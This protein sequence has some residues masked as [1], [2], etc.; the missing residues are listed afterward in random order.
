M[1]ILSFEERIVKSD[2]TGNNMTLAVTKI[3]GK[4]IFEIFEPYEREA[5]EN[6][7]SKYAGWGYEYQFADRLFEQLIT[8]SSA[9]SENEAALMICNG[10]YEEGCWPLLVTIDESDTEITWR[11]F[12]NHHRSIPAQDGTFWDYSAFPSFHFSK[13]AYEASLI[14]LLKIAGGTYR[15]STHHRKQLENDKICG[16]FSCI[17]LFPPS[18][19]IEWCYEE[20]DGEGVTAICPYCGIDAIIGESTGLPMTQDF[21]QLLNRYS[22]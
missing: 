18:E 6:N 8:K 14:S 11:G 9:A 7:G 10:C 12:H 4:P 16:C 2:F 21:L 15:F 22:F 3:N 5:A 19:I 1:D 13:E 17:N 20:E